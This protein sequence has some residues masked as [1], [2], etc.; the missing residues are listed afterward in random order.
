MA[1]PVQVVVCMYVQP[2][3]GA[4]GIRPGTYGDGAL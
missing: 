1:R 2:R 3:S 4:C